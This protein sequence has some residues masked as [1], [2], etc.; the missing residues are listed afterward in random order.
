MAHRS[1]SVFDE[2]PAPE[3][4]DVESGKSPAST[5]EPGARLRVDAFLLGLPG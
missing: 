5:E 1:P 4:P 2:T 3:T